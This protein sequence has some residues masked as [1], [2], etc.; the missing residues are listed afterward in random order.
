[1]TENHCRS[2]G[3]GERDRGKPSEQWS[4]ER[5]TVAGKQETERDQERKRCQDFVVSDCSVLQKAT[6]SQLTHTRTHTN[7]HRHTSSVP[8]V[9]WRQR[10]RDLT[11][12]LFTQQQHTHTHTQPRTQSY[13]PI[14]NISYTQT[15][16]TW[17]PNSEQKTNSFNL[18]STP[19]FY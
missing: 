1:M 2:T 11:I 12:E 3:E 18:P 13:T 6:N 7:I 9:T 16:N 8:M 19:R 17:P 15:E 5:W 10:G 4:E 14:P